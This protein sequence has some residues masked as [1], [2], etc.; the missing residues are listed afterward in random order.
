MITY[1][2]TFLVLIQHLD[3]SCF[4]VATLVIVDIPGLYQAFLLCMKQGNRLFFNSTLGIGKVI[5]FTPSATL[6]LCQCSLTLLLTSKTMLEFFCVSADAGEK[7][8]SAECQ[9]NLLLQGL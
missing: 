6:S 4:A 9:E 8:F 5:L 3:M 2:L 7:D 1:F